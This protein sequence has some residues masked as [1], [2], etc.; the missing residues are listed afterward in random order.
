VRAEVATVM[1]VFAHVALVAPP[2]AL[3]GAHGA[4]FVILASD[5]PLPIDAVRPGLDA[6]AGPVSVLSGIELAS[7]VDGADALTDDYA[8]VDQLLGSRP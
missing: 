7:F 8:P 1:R 3:A 4:N 6:L 2:Q 5:T